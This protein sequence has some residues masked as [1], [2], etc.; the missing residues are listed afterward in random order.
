MV[1]GEKPKSK[2][3]HHRCHPAENQ[4]AGE[5]QGLGRCNVTSSD[6]EQGTENVIKLGRTLPSLQATFL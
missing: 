3:H 4:R 2:Y 1:G 6:Q 5:S